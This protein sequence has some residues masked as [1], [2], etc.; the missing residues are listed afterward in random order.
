[1]HIEYIF[2]LKS[3]WEGSET[4]NS[5]QPCLNEKMSVPN[6]SYLI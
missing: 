6:I 4:Y 2:G 5:M 1:M 3:G